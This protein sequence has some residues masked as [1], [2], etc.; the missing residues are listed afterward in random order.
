[1]AADGLPGAGSPLAEQT[2]AALAARV[3]GAPGDGPVFLRSFDGPDGQGEPGEPALRSAAFSYDNA[4]AAIALVACE[5]PA[6]AVRIGAALLAAAT[7]DRTGETGRLRNAYR[8]GPQPDRPVPPMGWWDAAANRWAEDPYQVG[9]ATGNVAWAA[10]ALLTLHEG[11]GDTAF[12]EGAARLAGW[13]AANARDPRGPGGFIGGLHGFDGSARP[14]TWKSTEHNADAAAVFGWLARTGHPGPWTERE[15]EARSFLD[16][17]WRA[18]EGG[19][20]IGTAPDGVT[21]SHAASGLDAQLW[22]LLLRDAPAAWRRA[23]DHAERAHGVGDG[24][25][26]NDDRDG[27]WLEGTAQAALVYRMLGRA[28]EA[29]RRLRLVAAHVSPGGYVWAADRPRITTG[30]AIGPDSTTDDFHYHRWPHLGATAWAALAA[31][32]WN[33]FTGQPVSAALP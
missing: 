30:L 10:L 3:D 22:P 5:R 6:A 11:T 33:P 12:L 1:M 8:A 2:C 29:D 24:F 27:V 17:V 18:G 13:I 16:A 7:D 23:M 20:P 21:V 9:T 25:D 32:G 4:L 28:A 26:F 15:A 14:L 31:R 19:F